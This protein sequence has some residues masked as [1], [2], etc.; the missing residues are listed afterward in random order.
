MRWEV[1]DATLLLERLLDA[2]DKRDGRSTYYLCK[3]NANLVHGSFKKW[4]DHAAD[5]T[6][7]PVRYHRYLN[8]LYMISKTMSDSVQ[9]GRLFFD[10]LVH[11]RES[12]SFALWERELEQAQKLVAELRLNEAAS[13]L[14]DHLIDVRRLP[15]FGYRHMIAT[16][17]WYISQAHFNARRRDDAMAHAERSLAITRDIG[18]HPRYERRY[19]RHLME[20]HQYFGEAEKA[21]NW[22]ERLADFFDHFSET[23]NARWHRSLAKVM[24][25]GEPLVRVIVETDDG[26]YELDDLPAF[27]GE[28]SLRPI[29]NRRALLPSFVLIKRA[30]ES[31]AKEQYDEAVEATKQAAESDPFDPDPPHTMGDLLL[32]SGDHA[33]AAEAFEKAEQLAPRLTNSE[34]KLWLI[35]QIRDGQYD[36]DVFRTLWP[37]WVESLEPYELLKQAQRAL[38]R[39]PKLALLHREHGE[40]LRAMGRMREAAESFHKGLDCE[41][42][43]RVR[44]QLLFGA[45]QA[46]E[47]DSGEQKRFVEQAA[48]MNGALIAGA[49]AK[50][51]DRLGFPALT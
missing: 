29:R 7:D 37:L 6:L 5:L 12:N 28:F 15:G 35:K 30:R 48:Q 49:M 9:Q 8:G 19:L 2:I 41:C 23:P 11:R 32:A 17:H 43:N 3:A 22:S 44:T 50:L 31:A 42:D 24:R 13:L 20:V 45:A 39:H 10:V 25:A 18:D 4:L 33:E 51:V 1:E 46:A 47:K 40:A 26:L 16:T 34:T 14:S 27:F 38:R 36:E 21:A